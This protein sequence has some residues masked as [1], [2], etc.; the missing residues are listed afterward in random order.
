MTDR[1]N[2]GR[3]E[4]TSPLRVV[5]IQ[6]V[7]DDPSKKNPRREQIRKGAFLKFSTLEGVVDLKIEIVIFVGNGALIKGLQILIDRPIHYIEAVYIWESG[8]GTM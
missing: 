1:A 8:T 6:T 4:V 7:N 3:M 2:G 5:R